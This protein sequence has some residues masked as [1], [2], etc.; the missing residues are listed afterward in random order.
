[1]K[2]EL[3]CNYTLRYGRL[4][5]QISYKDGCNYEYVYLLQEGEVDAM[6]DFLKS[7]KK[8]ECQPQFYVIEMKKGYVVKDRK[9]CDT[10]VAMFYKDTG[11]FISE[12]EANKLCYKLNKEWGK[13]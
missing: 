2:L 9:D 1:M 6:I 11:A 7:I 5:P 4:G 8:K 13:W 3:G 10:I 12:D